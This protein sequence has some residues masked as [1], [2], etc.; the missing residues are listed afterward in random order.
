MENEQPALDIFPSYVM[1]TTN[2][3]GSRSVSDIYTFEA[4]VNRNIFLLFIIIFVGPFFTP[5]VALFCVFLY[6]SMI[7]KA[8]KV[9]PILGVLICGY[10][11]Y[12]V[13]HGWYVSKVIGNFAAP[14]EKLYLIRG[15]VTML[16]VNSVLFVIGNTLFR[17]AFRNNLVLF[18]Y[19]VVITILAYLIGTHIILNLFPIKFV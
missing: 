18:L 1:E 2:P 6:I 10:L 14:L 5:F 7:N 4:F 9:F 19:V 12:D 13:T 11:L 17:L 15:T 16:I 3:D 8:Q